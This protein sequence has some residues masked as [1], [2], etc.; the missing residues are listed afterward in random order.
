MHALVPGVFNTLFPASDSSQSSQALGGFSLLN[1]NLFQMPQQMQMSQAPS[2]HHSLFSSS[3]LTPFPGMQ[4]SSNSAS[5]YPARPGLLSTS[6]AS[7][8]GQ[9]QPDQ[10]LLRGPEASA[11]QAAEASMPAGSQQLTPSLDPQLTGPPKRQLP[12]VQAQ[13]APSIPSQASHF[14]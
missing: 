7:S 13:R 4:S 9:Q 6:L 12:P 11:P 2:E 5:P 1:F 3:L 8:D 14:C 10:A